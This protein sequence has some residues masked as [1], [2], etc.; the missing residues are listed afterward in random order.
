MAEQ[1]HI[2]SISA[3]ITALERAGEGQQATADAS[4]YPDSS[5]PTY[6]QGD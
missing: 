5:L 2:A 6:N 4:A 3:A 1:H